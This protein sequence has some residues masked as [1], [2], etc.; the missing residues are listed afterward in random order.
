MKDTRAELQS[1]NRKLFPES[2]K[3]TFL[4]RLNLSIVAEIYTAIFMGV[5][6]S[7]AFFGRDTVFSTEGIMG[8]FWQM[9][10]ASA[11]ILVG[12]PLAISVNRTTRSEEDRDALVSLCH[13]IHDS[14]K[15][16][17]RIIDSFVFFCSIERKTSTKP[18][19]AMLESTFQLRHS[20]IQNRFLNAVIDDAT[21]ELAECR[22]R[23]S[24]IS[25]EPG[26]PD[27]SQIQE[28]LNFSK[29]IIG[30]NH[31][32]T[33]PSKDIVLSFLPYYHKDD[34]SAEEMEACAEGLE[35]CRCQYPQM[36]DTD[37]GINRKLILAILAI[38]Q[39]MR[40]QSIPFEDWDSKRDVRFAEALLERM[41]ESSNRFSNSSAT[42]FANSSS[43]ELR[44]QKPSGN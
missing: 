4:D 13:M 17:V 44:K 36:R 40:H 43:K 26:K 35:R 34:L 38:E 5:C 19:L 9:Y 39:F 16:N 1:L 6:V 41:E 21:Y 31:H 22:E 27:P 20:L 30:F 37:D 25:V 29:S 42:E 14:L 10:I 28:F 8:V 15:R 32:R 7:S 23:L 12:I 33:L 2:S 24:Q 11:A 18:Y 3:S